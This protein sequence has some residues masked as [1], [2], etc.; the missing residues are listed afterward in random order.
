LSKNVELK[1]ENVAFVRDF[2][3]NYDPF[4]FKDLVTYQVTLGGEGIVLMPELVFTMDRYMKI[5]TSQVFGLTDLLVYTGGISV[6]I[7][8]IYGL[9]AKALLSNSIEAR[10][11]ERLRK[12]TDGD[13]EMLGEDSE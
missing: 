5:V 10:V 6:S 3:S 8:S 13:E 9:C 4:A 11:F 7:L 1:V 2:Y 12:K